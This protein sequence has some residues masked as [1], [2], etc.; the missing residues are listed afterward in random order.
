MIC[1]PKYT[2]MYLHTKQIQLPWGGMGAGLVPWCSWEGK[3]KGRGKMSIF[4]DK[5]I[6]KCCSRERMQEFLGRSERSKKGVK[7][8]LSCPFLG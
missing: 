4:Q 7:P 5:E 6:E 2:K 8:I 1:V 3:G